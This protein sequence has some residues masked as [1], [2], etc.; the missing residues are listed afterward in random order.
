M[1]YKEQDS[2]AF[3]RIRPPQDATGRKAPWPKNQDIYLESVN[4]NENL[5]K[6]LK[7]MQIDANPWKSM[8]IDENKRKS[9]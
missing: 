7:Y 8:N 5:W 6:S 4:I 3:G 1:T 2:G 9:M